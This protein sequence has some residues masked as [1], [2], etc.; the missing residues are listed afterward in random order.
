MAAPWRGAQGASQPVSCPLR[1]AR[2]W[3][4]DDESEGNSGDEDAF[5]GGDAA[6]GG[7]DGDDGDG[8]GNT[9]HALVG[10]NT[11]KE[12]GRSGRFFRGIVVRHF[13]AEDEAGEE[14]FRIKYEDGDTEDLNRKELEAC[15]ASAKK[16]KK[17]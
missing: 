6:A 7:D 5:R 1:R 16:R 15:I 17:C 11:T 13:P 10:S 12:F 3:L 14:L 9:H 8:D 2:S 4:L